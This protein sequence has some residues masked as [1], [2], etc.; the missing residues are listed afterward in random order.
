MFR[1]FKS[2]VD[3]YAS[4]SESD[5]PPDRLWPFLM[6]YLRPARRVMIWTTLTVFLVAAVEILLIWY[7]GRLV[8][9][10]ADA[11]RAAIWSSHGLELGLVALF[12]LVLRPMIQTRRRPS[13]TSR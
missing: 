11:D 13:S 12:I 6:E 4:Y 2:L 10:L 3:P 9:V 5:T 1:F 8:D 7:A